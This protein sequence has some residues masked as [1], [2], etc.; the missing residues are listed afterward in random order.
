MNSVLYIGTQYLFIVLQF[1]MDSVLQNITFVV[2]YY[3]KGLL[4]DSNIHNTL[5]ELESHTV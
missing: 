2:F 1:D 3:N 4:W 5:K